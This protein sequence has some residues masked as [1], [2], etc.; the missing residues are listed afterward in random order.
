MDWSMLFVTL[1][2][3]GV[4]FILITAYPSDLNIVNKN[5]TPELSFIYDNFR[6][7]FELYKKG[8]WTLESESFDIINKDILIEKFKVMEEIKISTNNTSIILYKV[9]WWIIFI[10]FFI[11]AFTGAISIFKD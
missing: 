4:C 2:L 8:I 3:V 6:E 10:L 11:L 1:L 5:V 7:E 9:F